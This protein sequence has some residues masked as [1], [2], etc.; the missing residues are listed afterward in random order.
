MSTIEETIKKKKPGKSEGRVLSVD[1]KFLNWEETKA[2]VGDAFLK[3][4][5]VTSGVL[6]GSV[7]GL[8]LFL[9]YINYLPDGG[10]VTPNYFCW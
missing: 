4:A 6:Q 8:L 1:G 3:R 7:L 10:Q 2:N 5:K 9:I